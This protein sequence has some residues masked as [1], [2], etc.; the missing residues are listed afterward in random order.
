MCVIYF[1][2]RIVFKI[3]EDLYRVLTGLFNAMAAMFVNVRAIWRWTE[4]EVLWI[5]FYGTPCLFII[6]GIHGNV[7]SLCSECWKNISRVFVTF[8]ISSH[9]LLTNLTSMICRK[10]TCF[11]IRCWQIIRLMMMIRDSARVTPYV[12]NV[13]DN[14]HDIRLC[15]VKVY[16]RW[17]NY[18]TTSL[19]LRGNDKVGLAYQ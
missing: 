1:D 8:W 7:Y 10:T 14:R 17:R 19:G 9:L 3:L 13:A 2:Q 12:R 4:L 16:I 6:V 18:I 11:S 15:I 5:L